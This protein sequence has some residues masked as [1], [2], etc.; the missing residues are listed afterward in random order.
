MDG[1]VLLLQ[2]RPGFAQGQMMRL[3]APRNPLD[4]YDHLVQRPSFPEGA[5]RQPAPTDP[6][7]I[8]GLQDSKLLLQTKTCMV[9]KFKKPPDNFKDCSDFVVTIFCKVKHFFLF[10]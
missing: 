1:R 5:I 6:Q 7:R 2:S 8:Q 9:I 3:A 10:F 4:P